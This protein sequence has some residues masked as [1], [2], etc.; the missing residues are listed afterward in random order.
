MRL[1]IGSYTFP[2]AIGV[3]GQLPDRPLDVMDLLDKAQALGVSVVQVADNLP[4]HRLMAGE[5]DALVEWA[6]EL[7]IRLEVGTRGIDLDHLRTYLVLAQRLGSPILRVVVDT[8]DHHP[9]EGEIVRTLC[10]FSP[11]LARAE[12]VLAIENHDRFAA[13]LLANILERVD[14]PY[15]GVCLDTANSF[16][17]L[18]GPGAVVEVLGP[19][20]ANLHVKDFAISR[21]EHAMGFT[22]EG[23]PAGQGQLDIPWL[24][25][26]LRHLG[27]DMNA[28]LELWTPPER[29][30][31]ETI[32][33]EAL[34][35]AQSVAYL[36]RLV[37]D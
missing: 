3:P 30:P 32:A 18:E 12:V 24:L 9:S 2:W 20:V 15:V 8:V 1:G 17:A 19:W 29:V 34:W 22:I 35:A 23:R 13:R 37:P 10:A 26:R 11:A 21:V 4:L 7:G 36:R 27:R 28:I 31:G 14:S 16:G 25:E 6:S 5:L 33:K